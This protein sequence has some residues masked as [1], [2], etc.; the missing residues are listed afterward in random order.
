M[1]VGLVEFGVLCEGRD[2]NRPNM[3]IWRNRSLRLTVAG[4]RL[5]RLRVNDLDCYGAFAGILPW[6]RSPQTSWDR[7]HRETQTPAQVTSL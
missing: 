3:L 7:E 5:A 2:L 4:D 6:Q 1:T